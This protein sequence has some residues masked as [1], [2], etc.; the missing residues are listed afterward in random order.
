MAFIGNTELI[1]FEIGLVGFF[2][3]VVP[4]T[5]K[6]LLGFT[7]EYDNLTK[8]IGFAP[9]YWVYVALMYAILIVF[10]PLAVYRIR[11]YGNWVSGVNM[12]ALVVFWIL[13]AFF[14]LFSIFSTSWLWVAAIFGF[15]SLGLAIATTW[16]FFQL[17]ILAGVLMVFVCVVFVFLL[18]LE[19]AIAFKNRAVDQAVSYVKSQAT[20]NGQIGAV[21]PESVKP[22]RNVTMKKAPPRT[23][24]SPPQPTRQRPTSL[25]VQQQ[26]LPAQKKI[27][28]FMRS[29][30]L[31]A[32]TITNRNGKPLENV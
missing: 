30:N 8:D 25:P 5:V 17:E 26:Q 2:G 6:Y 9:S 12:S 13:Q 3:I 15:V 23:Q 21:L 28:Q 4:E 7:R 10:E 1:L 18:I 27:P 16:L 14:A 32:T 19:L 11:L 20:W 31:F 22:Q 29:D 24:S